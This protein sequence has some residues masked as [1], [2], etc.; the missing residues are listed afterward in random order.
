[1][2]RAAV[3][4]GIALMAISPMGLEAQGG[5]NSPIQLALVA[6]VQLV[7]ADRSI[8]G[9]RLNLIYGVNTSVV[10]LDVGLVNRN[11]AGVSK[12]LQYGIVNLVEADFTGWQ[13]G[14]VN[15]TRGAFEG[16]QSGA[17]NS[18]G[19]GRGL[20]WGVVNISDSFNGLQLGLVNYAENMH[21]LQI[22]LV[23]I[24]KQNGAFPVFPIVNWSF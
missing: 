8:T 15:I 13:D 21:G 16:L 4:L 1:M 20:Q 12:G 9:L 14:G 10:G 24:I 19:S 6:P 3:A 18:A 11:T 17:V 23:N 5:G 7:G 22:G 2:K